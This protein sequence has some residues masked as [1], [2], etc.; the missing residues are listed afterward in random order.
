MSPFAWLGVALIGSIGALSRFHVDAVVQRMTRSSFPLG[1][2]AI[3]LAGAFVLGL[4]TG[5]AVGGTTLTLIGT[6]GIGSFTTFSTWMF[7]SERLA[8]DGELGLAGVNVVVSLLVGVGAAAL[9]WQIGGA[10]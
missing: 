3:N 5:G 9:G 4:L 2:L 8:E 10:L 7:E 6:S 1:T